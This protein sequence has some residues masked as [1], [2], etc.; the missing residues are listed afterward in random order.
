MVWLYFMTLRIPNFAQARVLVV[1]DV[2]LDRYWTGPTSRISPEAP[3]PIVKVSAIEDRA[4]GAGNVALNIASLTANASLLG[5]VGNDDNAHVLEQTLAHKNIQTQFT[6]IDTHPT[7]TKLRVLSRN[8]QLIRLDFEESFDQVDNSALLENFKQQVANCDVIILSDYGKGALSNIEAFIKVGRDAG[9]PVL[10]DPKGTQF[11][12]YRGASLITPN[13]SEFEGV[14]G[15]CKDEADL[16]KKGFDLLDTAG[17]EALLVTRSEKGMTLFQKGEQPVH[18]AATAREVYDVTGAGDTVISVLA[19]A[20]AAGSSLSEA[21]ALANAAAALVVAKLGTATVSLAELRR[22]AKA[23]EVA[24]G[25]IMS[26]DALLKA[27]K[28][29]QLAGETIVMTN[30][31]FD[32]LH[33]GHVSYLRNAKKLGDRLVVA[34]NTDASVKRLKGEGRPINP[35]EHRM[36][37]LAGLESVDWVVPFSEDTPQNLIAKMLPDILVK[38]GDYK[39]ADIAGGAEVIANG[40]QVQVLNFEDGCSTTNI[41]NSIKKNQ[42]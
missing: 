22:E 13:L 40:G 34:V 33:P 2:M 17:L 3:V 15:H 27:I 26:E 30:G 19:A 21:T 10:I 31:C 39:I 18:L 6:K 37:V 25:G 24:H 16:V 42:K 7:I 38:G 32:L 23:D 11:E 28:D 4:G 35:T 8:Q 9:K 29:S 41:I 1:G 20:V 14:V 36:D 5:L 12:R